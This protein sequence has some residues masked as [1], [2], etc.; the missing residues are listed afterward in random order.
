MVK[1]SGF[2]VNT[3]PNFSSISKNFKVL[4]AWA[5]AGFFLER[6]KFSRRVGQKHTI[7]L[8][9]AY[10]GQGGGGASAPSEPPL[11]T[12]MTSSKMLS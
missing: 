7:C 8:K 1:F 4:Q 3:N 12:P 11:R 10:A 9:N 2:Q 6:A 5:S